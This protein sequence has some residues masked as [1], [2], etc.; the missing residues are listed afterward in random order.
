[1]PNLYDVLSADVCEVSPPDI[2]ASSPTQPPKPKPG[3][4]LTAAV[5]TIDNDYAGMLLGA[6]SM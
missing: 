1:M 4:H 2:P 6:V 5:E 3:T